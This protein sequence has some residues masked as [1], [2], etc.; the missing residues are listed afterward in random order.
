[1]APN[2]AAQ[3]RAM[4]FKEVFLQVTRGELTWI[5]A[6]EVLGVSARTMR[7]WR[8]RYEQRGLQGLHDGRRV[9]RAH[10]SVPEAVLKRWMKL[11]ERR[12]RGFNTRHFHSLL[13]RRH[14]GCEWSYTVVRRALLAAG[15]IKKKRPRGRHFVRREPRACFGELLHIDGSRHRWLTLCPDEWQS[16]IVVVD[17]ATKEVLYA[18]LT[19]AESTFAILTALG[20]V[21]RAHGIPQALY[22]D[23]ASWAT[24]TAKAGQPVDRSRRTQ[25]GRALER[26]GIEHIL[27]YS[28]QARG[29]SERVN[30]TL[31]DRLVKE[32]K[33]GHVR[34]MERANRYLSSCFLPAHNDDFRR[35]PRDPVSAFAP[36]GAAD[37]ENILCH[38]ESR[39]VQRDNTVTLDGVRLQI[40]R[41]P[42]RATCA[43]LTVAVRRHLDGIH[44][45]WWGPKL[46]GRYSAQGKALSREPLV[47][48]AAS[49]PPMAVA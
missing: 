10:N 18:Q 40:A 13:R 3:E 15:L 47:H 9:T 23:R 16:L 11:Y 28:P 48:S 46:L 37:L 25:V 30:R 35:A 14:G 43:D 36:L 2:P 32:L 8:Y 33:D 26:L 21:L 1:M 49:A 31:Q 20:T 42:G 45:V 29:R 38:E 6:A 19:E 7:R 5:Q 44:T 12:Y 24:F 4:K 39:T 34:T 22:S 17:D 41:Q 27:A